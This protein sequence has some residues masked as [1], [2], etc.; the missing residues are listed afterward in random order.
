MDTPNIF[1]MQQRNWALSYGMPLADYLKKKFPKARFA[2]FC[3]KPAIYRAVLNS[4]IKYEYVWNGYTHD[5]EILN[6][7]MRKKISKISISDIEKDLGIESVWLNLINVDRSLMYTFGKKWRFSYEQ[8]LQDDVLLDLVRYNYYFVKEI[9]FKKFNPNIIILPLVGSLFHNV[10]YW[11][12]KKEGVKCWMPT[13][14]K[15]S[16]RIILTDRIDYKIFPKKV[17]EIKISEKSKKEAQ[18][19]IKNFKKKYIPP[20]NFINRKPDRHNYTNLKFQIKELF[21]FFP[22]YVISHIRRLRD[23]LRSKLYRTN[24]TTQLRYYVIGYF[25]SRYWAFKVEKLKYYTN[26]NSIKQNFF[27][28][29]LQVVPEISANLWA[30]NNQNFFET[31]RATAMN[32]PGKYTLIVKEHP[33]MIGWR[34]PNFYKKISRM[35]NVKI[36]NAKFTSDNIIRNYNCVGVITASGTTG[37]EAVMLGKLAFTFAPMYYNVLPNSSQITNI[38]EL[39]KI[40]RKTV[41]LSTNKIQ[42]DKSLKYLLEYLVEVSFKLS[43][44]S[45]WGLQKHEIDPTVLFKEYEKKVRELK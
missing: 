26:L 45:R 38:N 22:R 41:S 11:F 10:L 4:K 40:L 2:A 8:Q 28:F 21:T 37:F 20:E 36:V 5:D 1:I 39:N 35:P 33:T 13:T 31:I 32:L 30:P 12:A 42:V 34:N 6:P 23:P 19:Y 29:P 24:D 3:Y 7:S 17:P 25:L 27:Y 9:V 18:S 15:I 16:G 44:S 43:Y 14:V